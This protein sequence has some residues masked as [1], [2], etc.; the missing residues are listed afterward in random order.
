VK[1]ESSKM[2]IGTMKKIFLW[3]SITLPTA[4]GFSSLILYILLL[5]Y[6]K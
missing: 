4:V 2:N 6:Q 3:W 1:D 5:I